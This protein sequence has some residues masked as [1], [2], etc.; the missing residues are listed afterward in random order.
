MKL[1]TTNEET[2]AVQHSLW[3][4]AAAAAKQHVTDDP[5]AAHEFGPV[6]KAERHQVGAESVPTAMP[7]VLLQAQ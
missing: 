4:R 5:F 7:G 6:E 3:G 1:P 2:T